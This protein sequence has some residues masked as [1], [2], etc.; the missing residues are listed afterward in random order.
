MIALRELTTQQ[1][2]QEPA[3]PLMQQGGLLPLPNG[4]A[5]RMLAGELAL[6][7]KDGDKRLGFGPV[8][9]ELSFLFDANRPSRLILTNVTS[10]WA[11]D[12][13]DGSVDKLLDSGGVPWSSALPLPGGA[14]LTVGV[15]PHDVLTRW[16]RRA[17]GWTAVWEVSLPSN[18][19]RVS[20]LANARVIVLHQ[21]WEPCTWLLSLNQ[22][23]LRP[24]GA[25]D[26]TAVGTLDDAAGSYLKLDGG[27]DGMDWW[28]AVDGLDAALDAVRDQPIEVELDSEWTHEVFTDPWDDALPEDD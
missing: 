2:P 19:Q 14:L 16:E 13:E 3:T 1:F 24:I 15:S 26:R 11:V 27:E 4:N 28:Y 12:I 8:G 22:D 5:L 23:G 17:E 21:K 25:F 6:T 20:L 18:T 10:V 9:P 7:T